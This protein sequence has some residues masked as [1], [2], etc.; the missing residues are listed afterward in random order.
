MM[1]LLV[2]FVMSLGV[3][4]RS[5]R[6]KRGGRFAFL[7]R[8]RFVILVFVEVWKGVADVLQLNFRRHA[9]KVER[10]DSNRADEP[11]ESDLLKPIV[12]EST[13]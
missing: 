9:A 11:W 6:T 1:R 13:D 10:M 3:E 7:V 4:T 12:N 2:I 8:I 5:N